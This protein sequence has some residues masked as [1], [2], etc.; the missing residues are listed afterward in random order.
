MPAPAPMAA[1]SS[2]PSLPHRTWI[3][4]TRFSARSSRARISRTRFRMCRAIPW[5]ARAHPWSFRSCASNAYRR[6]P[7][8][9][10]AR[11][12]ELMVELVFLLLGTLVVWLGVSGRISFDRRSVSWLVLSVALL[13]WGLLALARP[14]QWRARWQKW[15][16]GLSL[17]LLGA[18]MLAATRVPF[19]W[20]GRLLALAGLV[21][22]LRGLIGAILIF[23]HS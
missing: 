22:I 8:L 9:S 2:S 21:L 13:A 15:N 19:L 1:S 10:P 11:L 20:V 16:R 23:R 18:I 14:G 17:L 4:A 7:M 5:T 12:T 6:P 3:I